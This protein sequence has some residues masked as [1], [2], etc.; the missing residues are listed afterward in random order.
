MA[1]KTQEVLVSPLIQFGPLELINYFARQTRGQDD[2]SLE[3][4]I[5]GDGDKD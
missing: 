1:F 5:D 4:N 3:S 2:K